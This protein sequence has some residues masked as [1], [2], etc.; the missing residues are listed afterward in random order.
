MSTLGIMLCVIL[1]CAAVYCGITL[2]QI[3]G[4]NRDIRK[5]REEKQKEQ[6]IR[7]KYGLHTPWSKKK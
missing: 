5:E 4:V 2:L 7:N 3:H 6:D 1:G